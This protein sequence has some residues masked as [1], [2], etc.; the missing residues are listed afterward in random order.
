MQV[1]QTYVNEFPDDSSTRD[2]WCSHDRWFQT[3]KFIKRRFASTRYICI[4]FSD[5]GCNIGCNFCWH[6]NYTIT[7]TGDHPHFT[8]ACDEFFGRLQ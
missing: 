1:A 5:I 7:H 3:T 2:S 4:N 8:S 6:F